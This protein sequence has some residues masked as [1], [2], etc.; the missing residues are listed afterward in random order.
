[1]EKVGG[2]YMIKRKQISF[3][4]TEEI[5]SKLSEI[6][7]VMGMT[8]QDVINGL[9]VGEYDRI[10]GNPQLMVMLEQMNVLKAQIDSF[11]KGG[12]IER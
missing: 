5:D 12:S 11:G 10:K 8:R 1:M 3:R 2:D 9:I 4:T 7:T 6:E